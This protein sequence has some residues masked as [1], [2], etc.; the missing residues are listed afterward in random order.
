VNEQQ[1]HDRLTAAFGEPPGAIDAVR[2]L[3]AQLEDA[4]ARR[5]AER[6]Y[7]RGMAIVAV[8]LTLLVVAGLLA[9]RVPRFRPATLTPGARPPAA[10]RVSACIAGAPA[11]LIVVDLQAQR[12]TAYDHGCQ[13]L[14]TPVTT[15]DPSLP[16]A[17]GTFHVLFKSSP[18]VLHSSWPMGSP[19]WFPDTAVHDYIAYTNSGDALHDAA[20]EPQSAFGPGSEDGRYASRGTVHLPL[21]VAER[22][23][24]WVQV[25][26]TVNVTSGG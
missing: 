5:P 6:G 10:A 23:Y 26:A 4:P 21:L 8:G 13:F 22:L 20:W 18:Y 17:A 25:G 14:T 15:G 7:P 16:T 2:R 1:I 9:T 3:R 24:G 12:L 11:Q 19:H